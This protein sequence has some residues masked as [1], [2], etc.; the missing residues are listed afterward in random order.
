MAIGNLG[1]P[2]LRNKSDQ[3]ETKFISNANEYVG[4]YA[5]KAVVMSD[6]S[7]ETENDTVQCVT[8]ATLSMP[9]A[10]VTSLDFE[11]GKTVN[12]AMAGI[13]VEGKKIPVLV[14]GTITDLNQG[15]G[16]ND[17]GY[18]VQGDTARAK[19]INALFRSTTKYK[20]IGVNNAEVDCAIIDIYALGDLPV[21]APAPAV[22]AADEPTAGS[23][24]FQSMTIAELDQFV[25]DNSLTL[26]PKGSGELK[27]DYANRVQVAFD[28]STN[29]L[30]ELN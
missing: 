15:V 14:Q 30:E 1:Y 7:N 5:G 27:P 17:S 19:K 9:F 16:I 13:L 10:G 23:V 22:M 8:A 12:E 21:A 26:E 24:D 4:D 6:S 11:V 20:A 29:P 3:I 28:E 2:L 18:F 25:I